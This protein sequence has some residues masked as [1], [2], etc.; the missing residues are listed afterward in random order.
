MTDLGPITGSVSDAAQRRVALGALGFW[1]RLPLLVVP[2]GPADRSADRPATE[3]LLGLRRLLANRRSPQ[4]RALFGVLGRSAGQRIEAVVATHFDATFTENERSCIVREVFQGL[5]DGGLAAFRGR[6][7]EALLDFVH[8]HADRGLLRAAVARWGL[9]EVRSAWRS[10]Y[11]DLLTTQ[12]V[13][14]LSGDVLGELLLRSLGRFQGGTG[15][16]LYV[17]VRTMCR[18]SVA[19][20]ARRKILDR[21][22]I[23]RLQR[24]APQDDPPLLGQPS[25]PA[26][27]RLRTEHGPP[28]ISE[29]DQAYLE[30]LL[31]VGGKLSSLAEQRGVTRS[32]VTKMV[33]R[34]LGRL[35]TLEPDERE[36]VGVWATQVLELRP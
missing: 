16:E 13:E 6:D 8:E 12:E 33:Q 5:F 9:K 27:P 3:F 10:R 21:Q 29:T 31:Q 35:D 34:I 17:Y 24:E 20:A 19:R 14:E 4:T 28:P 7:A 26:P 2:A 1:E 32:S 18:R 30:A 22:S 25:R 36:Q 15:N 23:R 11:A